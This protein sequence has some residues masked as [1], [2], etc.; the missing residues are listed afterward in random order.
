MLT[1][2]LTAGIIKQGQP[3]A[4]FWQ[5]FRQNKHWCGNDNFANGNGKFRGELYIENET[6][7]NLLEV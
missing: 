4:N 5:S 3:N 7:E 2:L 6:T 1:H